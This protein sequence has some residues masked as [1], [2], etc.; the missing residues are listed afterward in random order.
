MYSDLNLSPGDTLHAAWIE[1]EQCRSDRFEV[2][3]PRPTNGDA[4]IIATSVTADGILLDTPTLPVYRAEP[5]ADAD[6][7]VPAYRVLGAAPSQDALHWRILR[8]LLAWEYP[9]QDVLDFILLRYMDVPRDVYADVREE[10]PA[11]LEATVDTL[12]AD[13][14]RDFRGSPHVDKGL[15]D[16]LLQE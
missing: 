4:E 5:Q 13:L 15:P 9:P 2:C 6:S 14:Y 12:V 11:A 3:E 8:L 10:S 7:I 16:L 1:Y